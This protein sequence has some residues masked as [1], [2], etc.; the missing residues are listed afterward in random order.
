VRGILADRI[1]EDVGAIAECAEPV[2]QLLGR[3][4]IVRGKALVRNRE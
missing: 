3:G 1:G 4:W 2:E